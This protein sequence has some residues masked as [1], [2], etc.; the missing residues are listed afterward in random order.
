[1][2]RVDPTRFVSS[3][4]ENQ[5]EYL[6]LLVRTERLKAVSMGRP[7][8]PPPEALEKVPEIVEQERRLYHSSL[9]SL[10]A[11]LAIAR[12]Q[13]SQR[14]QELK[15]VQVGRDQA[16][17]SYELAARELAVTKPLASSGRYPK[18]SC[19]DSSEM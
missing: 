10:E 11:Q 19:C 1:M 16:A 17:R 6:S 15:E 4:R 5:A 14:N 7:F 3:L 12:Q 9:E 13:L 2:L 18:W 8:V